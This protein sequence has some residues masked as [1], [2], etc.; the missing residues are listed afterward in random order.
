VCVCVCVCVCVSTKRVKVSYFHIHTIWQNEI[1]K[2]QRLGSWFIP[3][4]AAPTAIS[5]PTST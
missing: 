3:V 2:H 4:K 5:S 1:N